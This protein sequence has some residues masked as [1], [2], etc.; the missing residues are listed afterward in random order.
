MFPRYVNWILFLISA[1][2][3]LDQV[4]RCYTNRERHRRSSLCQWLPPRQ[5]PKCLSGLSE[6]EMRIN[7]C[8]NE[9]QVAG[10]L[11]NNAI[12]LRTM[13]IGRA[14]HFVKKWEDDILADLLSFSRGS[15]AC[16]VEFP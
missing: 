15:T 6:I 10:Y 1:I 14:T 13:R 5:V 7:G 2:F 11:L 12:V 3:F 8:E 4:S 9:L 16:E